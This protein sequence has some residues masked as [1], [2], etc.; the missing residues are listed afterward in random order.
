MGRCQEDRQDR[1]PAP[2]FQ[3]GEGSVL[4]SLLLSGPF[5]AD[6]N[7]L[8][9]YIHQSHAVSPVG[10]PPMPDLV[11]LD[12]VKKKKK[13][14]LHREDP[15][16]LAATAVRPLQLSHHGRADM[17]AI[18][19]PDG[20]NRS[21]LFQDNGLLVTVLAMELSNLLFSGHA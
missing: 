4:V 15:C 7:Y 9:R 14:G 11:V 3:S 13:K 18:L 16:I 10:G 12:R 20:P 19:I 8:L 21:L 6:Y 5:H 17:L 2:V 1:R